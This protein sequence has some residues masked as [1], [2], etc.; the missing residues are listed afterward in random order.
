MMNLDGATW[1]DCMDAIQHTGFAHAGDS[2]FDIWLFMR[3]HQ[4]IRMDYDNNRLVKVRYIVLTPNH[5]M[6]SEEFDISLGEWGVLI[7]QVDK[8]R[9]EE[10]L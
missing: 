8:Y 10:L 9:M 3:G 7:E 4:L 1:I 2:K 5:R 6:M